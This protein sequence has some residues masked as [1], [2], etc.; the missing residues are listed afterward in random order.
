[1][2]PRKCATPHT[3]AT[4]DIWLSA[5]AGSTSP[6]GIVQDPEAR[7]VFIACDRCTIQKAHTLCSIRKLYII[8]TKKS[9]V[10]IVFH[11]QGNEFANFK[12]RMIFPQTLVVFVFIF[13]CNSLGSGTAATPPE[14]TWLAL[15]GQ[16]VMPSNKTAIPVNREMARQALTARRMSN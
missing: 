10:N 8:Y 16:L 15:V 7:L 6:R 13:T 1:M 9:N 5:I 14:C 12:S 4:R 11:S 3:S 2:L